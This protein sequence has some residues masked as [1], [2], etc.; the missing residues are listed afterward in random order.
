MR[1]AYTSFL[2]TS[3]FVASFLHEIVSIILF[4]GY[5]DFSSYQLP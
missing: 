4:D 1:C 3:A 5:I 2:T